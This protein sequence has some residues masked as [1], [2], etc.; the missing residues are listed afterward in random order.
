MPLGLKA[1]IYELMCTFHIRKVLL[2]KHLVYVSTFLYLYTIAY[3]FC[4]IEIIQ[5]FM[6]KIIDIY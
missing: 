2:T 4:I 1:R 5:L 6:Y 3:I